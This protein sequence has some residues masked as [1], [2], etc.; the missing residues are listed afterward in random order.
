MRWRLAP[1][2]P[3]RSR[4]VW[5]LWTNPTSLA[6]SLPGAVMRLWNL[7]SGACLAVLEGHAGE[8]RGV[9]VSADFTLAISAS[10]DKTLRLWDLE[11][12]VCRAAYYSGSP[13]QSIS[14]DF[15]RG[16][17]V[18][19]TEDGQ[20][21]I[22]TLRQG[23]EIVRLD[24]RAATMTDDVSPKKQSE[25]CP[26]PP[27]AEDDLRAKIRGTRFARANEGWNIEVWTGNCGGSVGSDDQSFE[28]SPTIRLNGRAIKI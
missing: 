26:T 23:M 10:S 4:P 1:H 25:R 20:I 13:F 22:L 14:A 16:R 18:C 9:A 2:S 15:G 19:G 7:E 6:K 17:I 8:I 27:R 3:R 24:E 12:G 28:L 5:V 11:S 21:H